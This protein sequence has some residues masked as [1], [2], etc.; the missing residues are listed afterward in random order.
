MNPPQAMP[1]KENEAH[2][3]LVRP[4][5]FMETETLDFFYEILSD[6]EKK[7]QQKFIF[8]K[9]R[10]LYLIAHAF[11]RWCLSRYA[12]LSPEEWAF[13]KSRHGK[14]YTEYCFQGKPLQFNLS[15]TNGLVG[16]VIALVHEVGV[17]V[18]CIRFD[19]RKMAVA[20]KHF[21]RREFH[22]LERCPLDE[23]PKR[24]YQYWT[25]KE[26]FSKAKG[27][28]LSIPLD[29]FTFRFDN[30]SSA[31]IDFDPGI[32]ENP[33]QWD[34]WL[35]EPGRNHICAVA[36]E[37]GNFPVTVCLKDEKDFYEA[38]NQSG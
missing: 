27:A 18:E 17:D 21:S 3:W 38:I 5:R 31:R 8:E 4:E 11:C 19:Q 14:P 16:C 36:V 34:F 9:D 6:E 7:Q 2:L 13:K 23:R 15:H 37:R 20:E 35:Y 33:E 28:G 1:M 22:D 32:P 29:R 30:G 24:F 12:D 10:H 25:L 26:A